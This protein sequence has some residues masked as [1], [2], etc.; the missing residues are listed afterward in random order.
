M[1]D[2]FLMAYVLPEYWGKRGVFLA[3][4]VFYGAGVAAPEEVFKPAA[5]PFGQT[6]NQP[7]PFDEAQ[8]VGGG[9]EIEMVYPRTPFVPALLRYQL[10]QFTSAA[11][12]RY[13]VD[14]RFRNKNYPGK[15]DFIVKGRKE[16]WDYDH[17]WYDDYTYNCGFVTLGLS[18]EKKSIEGE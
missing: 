7:A 5:H 2:R 18:Y 10:H 16:I 14:C 9:R 8:V 6:N 17:R 4:G 13:S 15:P 12:W 1:E 11:Q 3:G